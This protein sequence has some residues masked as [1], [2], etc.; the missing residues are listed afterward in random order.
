MAA[1]YS[2]RKSRR[3]RTFP[4]RLPP[5]RPDGGCKAERPKAAARNERPLGG[6]RM[7]A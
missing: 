6:Q 1:V 7:F 3:F 2:S 4:F 5:A